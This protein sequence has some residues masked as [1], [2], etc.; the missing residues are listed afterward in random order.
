MT[1]MDRMNNIIE[2]VKDMLTLEEI[3]F[4]ENRAKSNYKKKEMS[5]EDKQLLADM[6][7]YMEVGK[8]YTISELVKAFGMNSQQ[9]GTGMMSHLLKDGKVIREKVKNKTLFSKV[10]AEG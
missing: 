10:E 6:L 5:D 3:E 9:K 8:Q 4:L 1:N 2:K 7:D